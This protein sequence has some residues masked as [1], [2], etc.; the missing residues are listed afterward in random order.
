MDF[1]SVESEATI[2]SEFPETTKANADGY[3]TDENARPGY[4]TLYIVS[5]IPS[6]LFPAHWAMWVPHQRDNQGT[7]ISAQG[8]PGTGFVHEFLR[9]YNPKEDERKPWVKAVAQIEERYILDPPE[10]ARST[11]AYN[12]LEQVG[13]SIPA[14]GKS[15]RSASQQG[16]MKRVAI[17]NCQTWLADFVKRLI[18]KGLIGKEAHPVLDECPK[19]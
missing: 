16:P 19:N 15:L 18:E 2:S 12:E 6:R 13:F 5:F 14:P 11:Q 10:E 8:D 7:L 9:E 3:T 17:Q 4:R 1:T